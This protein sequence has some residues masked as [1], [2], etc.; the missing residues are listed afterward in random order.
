MARPVSHCQDSVSEDAYGTTSRPVLRVEG[1]RMHLRTRQGIVKAVDDVSFNLYP[2]ETL[3]L[4]GESG[5][6]KSMTCLSI[7]RLIP[8]RVGEIVEGR[9]VFQGTDLLRVSA[10]EMRRYRGRH[11]AI[12]LQDPMTSLNPVLRVGEQVAEPLRLHQ[13]LRGK[14]LWSQVVAALKH[15]RIPG[16]EIARNSY[17]HQLSGGMRQRVGGAIA[18][19]PKPEVLIADEPTTALDATIQAQYLSL[20]KDIQ[21]QSQ[22]AIIFVTHDFGIVATMCD[23]V[24]VMYAGKLVEIAGVRD[25]FFN[26]PWHPYTEALLRSVPRLDQDIGRLFAIEGQ[27]PTLHD[28][29]PGCSFAPRCAYA[30]D[31]CAQKA[32]PVTVGAGRSAS[33]WKLVGYGE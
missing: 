22:L 7:L 16:P 32:P 24:A 28:L 29:P 27:P 31:R 21:K 30:R 12:I 26:E 17:P 23:R 14:A 8:D 15:M 9:V 11:I 1:L 6:G 4:V 5:C 3:G 10:A 25:L 2:G 33:C 13:G 19:A 18:L 20:L